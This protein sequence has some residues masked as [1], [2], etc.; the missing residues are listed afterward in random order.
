MKQILDFT[1]EPTQELQ[2]RMTRKRK[3]I[4][5]ALIVSALIGAAALGIGWM[6]LSSNESLETADNIAERVPRAAAT[7]PLRVNPKNPRYFT[8]GSG[9]AIY[10]TGS[11]TWN[12][13]QEVSK[14]APKFEYDKYLQFLQK[15]NHNFIR[16]WT[17]ENA[18]WEVA[19]TD[20]V[21]IHP[22]PLPA[23]GAGSRSRR[24]PKI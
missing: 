4:V 23:H 7:G 24:R 21:R 3:V 20:K 10:L 15:A 11:H 14:L 19:T 12:N 16:L 2:K 17:I 13:L 6:L 8:D 22:L 18:A 5:S 1:V 9:R